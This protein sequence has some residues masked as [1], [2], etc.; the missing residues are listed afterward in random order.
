MAGYVFQRRGKSVED[1]AK[2]K[3]TGTMKKMDVW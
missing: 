1:V 2:R 3:M